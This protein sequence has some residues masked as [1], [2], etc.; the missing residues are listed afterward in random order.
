MVSPLS[1][2]PALPIS[3]D[4]L[5]RRRHF[6]FPVDANR[7][8]RNPSQNRSANRKY[9][10]SRPS[11]IGMP[12]RRSYMRSRADMPVPFAYNNRIFRFIPGPS[13]RRRDANAHVPY[14][15]LFRRADTSGQPDPLSGVLD[16]RQVRLLAAQIQQ[17]T[18][19]CSPRTGYSL[20]SQRI[21]SP[22][23]RV[24]NGLR[25]FI[26]K[27]YIRGQEKRLRRGPPGC[28]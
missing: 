5:Y 9:R 21:D 19:P 8:R 4:H 18:L 27:R 11:P 24:H 26:V 15:W 22:W 10:A 1:I 6:P 17:C 14:P 3:P 2:C 13:Q 28:R 25:G 7:D 12:V 16:L 23:H 20:C